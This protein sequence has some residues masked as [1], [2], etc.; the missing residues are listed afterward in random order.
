MEACCSPGL[1]SLST[2]TPVQTDWL[3]T[4]PSLLCHGRAATQQPGLCSCS[5]LPGAGGICNAQQHQAQLPPDGSTYC[6][7]ALRQSI[8]HRLPLLS[9][10][11]R[12]LSSEAGAPDAEC[13]AGA[14]AAAAAAA[15]SAA[16]L[17][18]CQL[19][20]VSVQ[21]AP[22]LLVVLPVAFGSAAT[23]V[24]F[25]PSKLEPPCCRAAA[26]WTGDCEPI[27]TLAPRGAPAGACSCQKP[28]AMRCASPTLARPLISSLHRHAA[29]TAEEV[30]RRL[31]C[32]RAELRWG[33]QS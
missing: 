27:M 2:E 7:A 12:P 29:A 31:H 32:N 18:G 28:V 4:S 24:A 3:R 33:E 6:A 23:S 13:I 16:S 25:M 21:P 9:L 14:A 8:R 20:A 5:S 30:Y 1:G 15:G 17:P 26:P 11:P 10:I 19:L 22:Q